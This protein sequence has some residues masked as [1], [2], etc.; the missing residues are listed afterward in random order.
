[1]KK[2][3]GFV[4]ASLPNPNFTIDLVQSMAQAGLDIV[5]LGVPFS[6]PVADGAV[7]E[8]ASLKA[9]KSGFKFEDIFDI[10]AQISNQIDTYIMGY[11]NMFYKYGFENYIKKA[12]S[13]K[14]KGSLIPDMPF[15]ESKLYQNIQKKYNHKFIDFVAPTDSKQRIKKLVSTT[16]NFVYLVAYAGIT[17]QA[18]QTNLSQTIKNI[19]DTTDTPIYL[20]FGV[21][22]KNAKEKSQDVDGLIVGSA[23]V[24]HLL[25]DSLN[26]KEKLDIIT[27]KTK[28]IKELI[29]SKD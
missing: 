5:E 21:N 24:K 20:G 8:K 28:T 9:I 19:R 26:F 10:S 11:T 16:S 22:E 3:V 7:I 12:N 14:I 13:L 1:M 23:F 27:N 25:D 2:L 15:E 29:C 6:D 18:K 4:T 17:G